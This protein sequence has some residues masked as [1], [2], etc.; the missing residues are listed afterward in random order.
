MTACLYHDATPR[1]K[2]LGKNTEKKNSQRQKKPRHL[3]YP[4]KI[5]IILPNPIE[6][7][8]LRSN[9]VFN[10]LLLSTVTN[11]THNELVKH[12]IHHQVTE[13]VH[14]SVQTPWNFLRG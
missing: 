12:H 13:G 11:P 7:A 6:N 3:T 14:D 9:T 8:A 2:K 10:F 1:A 4:R 5:E